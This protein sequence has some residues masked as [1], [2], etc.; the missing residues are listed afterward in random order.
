MVIH[1]MALND[2]ND[3]YLFPQFA[4]NMTQPLLAVKAERL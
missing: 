2:L 3:R 1:Q 4:S